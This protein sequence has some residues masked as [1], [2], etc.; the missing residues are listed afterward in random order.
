MAF[1]GVYT[2]ATRLSHLAC[3]AS[4]HQRDVVSVDHS[5]ASQIEFLLYTEVVYDKLDYS[6]Y[7]LHVQ[8]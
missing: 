3:F 4:V 6:I 1:C 8:Q 7:Q 5:G 2:T